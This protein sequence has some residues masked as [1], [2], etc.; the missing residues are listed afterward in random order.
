[1]E[2]NPL[3]APCYECNLITLAE[4]VDVIQTLPQDDRG[5]VQKAG[6]NKEKRT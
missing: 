5:V 4:D 6:S 2:H 1:M 3:R